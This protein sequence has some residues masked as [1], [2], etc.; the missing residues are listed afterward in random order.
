MDIT[1]TIPETKSNPEPDPVPAI[2]GYRIQHLLGRGGMG[3]VYLATDLRLGRPVAIKTLFAGAE[4]DLVARFQEEVAAVAAIHHPN[5]LQIFGAGDAN[6]LPYYAMEYVDG[7]SLDALLDGKPVTPHEAASLLEPIARAIQ[8]CHENGI[9][10]RDLKPANV[11]LE[12][13]E[14]VSTQKP[15]DPKGSTIEQATTDARAARAG[16]IGRRVPKIADF[17]LA[18]R[19]HDGANLT[20]TGQIMG[21]PSYMAPEQATGI[22]TRLGPA[23]DIYALGAMLY[24]CLTGRPPFQSP[25]AMQTMMMVVSME[26]IPP[27]QL[28]PRLPRDLETI[29]LKCLEKAPR[30]RYA[31]AGD[32]AD[33]LRR[34]LDGRPIVARPVGYFERGLKWTRRRPAAAG[35]VGVSIAGVLL[36]AGGLILLQDRNRQLKSTNDALERSRDTTARMLGNSLEAV[37]RML[38]KLS[39]DLAEVPQAEPVRESA[40]RDAEELLVK[41][42]ES[43]AG[44]VR[45]RELIASSQVKLGDLYSLR[46]DFDTSAK[47]YRDAIAGYE[48][49]LA[50]KPDSPAYVEGAFIARVQYGNFL[51]R[52]ERYEEAVGE[53]TKALQGSEAIVADPTLAVSLGRLRN[54]LANSYGKLGQ[55]DLQ[56]REHLKNREER[57]RRLQDNP[58]SDPAKVDLSATQNNLCVVYSSRKRYPEA[59][60]ALQEAVALLSSLKRPRPRDRFEMGKAQLNMAAL[61]NLLDDRV[62]AGRWTESAVTTFSALASDFSGVP[63]YRFQNAVAKMRLSAFQEESRA[64]ARIVESLAILE[65]LATE[66]PGIPA[67]AAERQRCR[68]VLDTFGPATPDNGLAAPPA[69]K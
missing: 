11:L 36:L 3:C 40:L 44:D 25:D 23:V 14:P 21:T 28:Q 32:L 12:T 31:S 7:G 8:H 58:D 20:R 35:L 2:S 47:Q 68:A 33:D 67:Y 13:G 29:C 41:V 24:E 5:V 56:E 60:A 16:A 57:R 50:E 45:G 39:D 55:P 18:K 37:N 42:T 10:H 61:S 64:R 6:G 59:K 46:G 30:R 65:Q 34:F 51:Y 49:L 9:L 22:V 27:R 48:S 4:P 54:N 52:R 63:D 19:M 15:A 38:V 43:D 17:G 53:F 66:F 1:F 69:K 26:P 62:E